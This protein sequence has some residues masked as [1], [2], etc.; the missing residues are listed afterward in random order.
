[1]GIGTL[2]KLDND[3]IRVMA[4]YIPKGASHPI[5]PT[6]HIRLQNGEDHMPCQLLRHAFNPNL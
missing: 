2:F 6:R 3:P 5:N 1:M 4:P